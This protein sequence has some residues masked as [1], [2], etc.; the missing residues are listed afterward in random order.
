[1]N[2][3]LLKYN[4]YYN[5]IVKKF[6]TLSEYLVTPYYNN[7]VVE[8]VNFN[9]N[10][11][12]DTT[13]IVNSNGKFD[14]CILADGN[15]IISRWFILE[16]KR[17]RNGQHRLTLRRDLVVDNYQEIINAPTFIEKATVSNSDPAIFNNE[18]MGFNQIKTKETPIKDETNSAWVVGYIPRD[19]FAE[20]TQINATANLQDTAD[21]TVDNLTNWDMYQYTT[22]PFK[23]KYNS[24]VEFIG[25][26]NAKYAPPSQG[27]KEVILGFGVDDAP[28]ILIPDVGTTPNN[29][30]WGIPGVDTPTDPGYLLSPNFEATSAILPD[31]SEVNNVRRIMCN[32]WKHKVEDT[33]M[34]MSYAYSNCHTKQETLDFENLN[35]KIIYESSSGLYRRIN[36]T[37]VQVWDEV[38]DITAGNLYESMDSN[39]PKEFEYYTNNGV[40]INYVISNLP[41]AT[42]F[43]I[44][45]SYR[46]YTISLEQ[47]PTNIKA[48]L[49]SNRY[50]LEDQPYDMFCI[51]YSETLAIYKNG[52]KLFNS[53]KSLAVNMAVEIGAKSGDKN[54]Y[55]VQLLPYCPVRY[56]ILED[57]TFDIGNAQVNYITNAQN[58]NIGVILW[59]TTSQFTVDIPYTINIDDYKVD[60]ECNKYRLVSPNYSGQFEFSAAKNGGVQSF[61]IDCS[62]K[63]Y[64]PYI[65]INPNFGRLYGQDFNDAR[66]LIC[67][68]DF[69]LPQVTNA[70]ANYQQNNK[71]FQNIFDR[72]I[73]NMEFN[74][75]MSNIQS[76]IGAATG[77]LSAGVTAGAVFGP[78]GGAISGLLSA[79]GGAADIAIN[80]ALQNEALDYK[81]DMFGY[82][83][84]NIKAMPTGLAKT[85]A[86]TY[87]NKIFPILEYYTCTDEEKQAL[88]DKIKYNGMTVMRVGKIVDFLQQDYSYI[89]GKVIRLESIS[90]DTNY[91][92]QIADEINKGVFIK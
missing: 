77:A 91:L 56:C 45:Y 8:N 67:G 65:H 79:A 70:W 49:N 54:I 3:Y 68:G 41:N 47:V 44:R 17:E 27:A 74:N 46:N 11:G 34:P 38:K 52:K 75:K 57:G 72:Q 51:P 60:N 59:A 19:S 6:N 21:I 29:L 63:P 26:A 2:L 1:M 30:D 15:D 90:D 9:P 24:N 32:N 25:F 83:L 81:K 14:Y 64:N 73:E 89:K 20:D 80:K 31:A 86:F 85:S 39:L 61:N 62:Y 10:D 55:D 16:C 35:G 36:I 92:N 40:K 82:E 33:F 4:N 22:T 71:N 28:S 58:E 84:G 13:Q 76:G 43:K 88:K 12:V 87:N 50:H 7:D 66:G 42:T 37:S 53:N 5:R 69:S 18:N 48:T 23:G 78:I